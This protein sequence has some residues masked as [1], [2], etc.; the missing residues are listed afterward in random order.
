MLWP[1][2]RALDIL[3]RSGGFSAVLD[4]L[5]RQPIEAWTE[6]TDCIYQWVLDHLCRPGTFPGER[7]SGS[8]S[9][10]YR[11]GLAAGVRSAQVLK[12]FSR[13][14]HCAKA[15]SEAGI[16][17]TLK[18]LPLARHDHSNQIAARGKSA[19]IA[20]HGSFNGC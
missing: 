17:A 18:A 12:C 7:V 13:F 20:T 4:L 6:T 10:S 2:G 5:E 11:K 9:Y 15:K 16:C 1:K 3:A 8:N 14:H 19:G